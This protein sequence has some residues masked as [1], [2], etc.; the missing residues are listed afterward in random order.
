M[1]KYSLFTLIYFLII[2]SIC[3]CIQT[4]DNSGQS[5]DNNSVELV[6][7]INEND[8]VSCETIFSEIGESKFE[9]EYKEMFSKIV[10]KENDESENIKKLFFDKLKNAKFYLKDNLVTKIFRSNQNTRT[11]KIRMESNNSSNLS[12]E[13]L[14]GNL[15]EGSIENFG[16]IVNNSQIEQHN[17]LLTLFFEL[18]NKIVKKGETWSLDNINLIDLTKIPI[19][20]K[21]V[22]ENSVKIVDII[23]SNGESIALIDYKISENYTE[24][25]SEIKFINNYIFIARGEFS[26]SKGK[27]L[28]YTGLMSIEVDNLGDKLEIREKFALVE[29]K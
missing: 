22:K 19:L 15:L 9:Y 17:T 12:T 16:K 1:K 10:S 27:W 28:G 21:S 5:L 25:I 8:T 3:G 18:P 26:I 23:E 11:Y 2:T 7:N 14:R 4:K 29:R 24:S 13:M 20:G 6:W